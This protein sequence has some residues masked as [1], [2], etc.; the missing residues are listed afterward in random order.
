MQSINQL[1]T[2]YFQIFYASFDVSKVFF[3]IRSE[4][5]NSYFF[6]PSKSEKKESSKEKISHTYTHIAHSPTFYG[7]TYTYNSNTYTLQKLMNTFF[8]L[9]FSRGDEN[10]S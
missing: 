7:S 2:A 8:L 9:Q 10:R 6:H 3:E 1:I 4:I 5:I